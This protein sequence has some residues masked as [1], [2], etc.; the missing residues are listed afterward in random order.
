M[1]PT[2]R[3]IW[4]GARDNTL[5]PRNSSISPV[6]DI[7]RRSFSIP[8]EF[9]VGCAYTGDPR[10]GECTYRNFT[11]V[12]TNNGFCYT[13]N[14]NFP[15]NCGD[16]NRRLR[17]VATGAGQRFSLSVLLN[18]G[19]D[20][21]PPFIQ[22]VGTLLEIHPTLVPPRPLQRGAL[23]PPGQQAY[24]GLTTTSYTFHD[25]QRNP[26]T[27]NF[28]SRYNIPNCVLD[29]LYTRVSK[30]CGCVPQGS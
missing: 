19:Q 24:I 26:S 18:I 23:V 12:A 5:C 22:D 2:L 1:C 20:N 30:T 11:P 7:F 29:N 9:I 6:S 21:Y 10:A 28:Y 17:L 15:V 27:L 4:S 25:C 8:R 14:R 13:F 16:N 3:I